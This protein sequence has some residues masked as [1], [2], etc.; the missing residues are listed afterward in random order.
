MKR[1]GID[2]WHSAAQDEHR[3]GEGEKQ[4]GKEQG[5]DKP[6]P[7]RKGGDLT[8]A[9]P[10]FGPQGP[11]KGAGPA[12]AE[13]VGNRREHDERRI[14]HGD[15]RRLVGLVEHPH[16]IGIGQAVNQGDHLA[17]D[18]GNDLPAYGLPDGHG[19]EQFGFIC[20]V[21]HGSVTPFLDRPA[22]QTDLALRQKILLYYI[23][24]IRFAK[25]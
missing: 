22:K 2:F 20:C 23:T 9:F 15:G 18:G 11:G 24:K 25:L 17:G 12:Y 13:E 5:A 14:D 7:E 8:G 6:A 10:V 3:A 16:K 1:D 21:L 19:F 4:K